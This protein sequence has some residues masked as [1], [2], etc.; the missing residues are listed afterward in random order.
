MKLKEHIETTFT[1][2][3]KKRYQTYLDL[4]KEL[5]KKK[6]MLLSL[7]LLYES[8]RLYLKTKLKEA[9]P[10]IVAKV[11]AKFTDAKG[12]EDLYKIGD[13]VKNLLWKNYDAENKKVNFLTKKEYEALQ[14]SV[15]QEIKKAVSFKGIP[16]MTQEKNILDHIAHTRNELSH[17]NA[18]GSFADIEKSIQT[19]L[20]DVSKRLI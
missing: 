8:S 19:L 10:D 5:F 2:N 6:Y 11:E 20:D 1:Y 18:K 13:F 14:K 7:S 15:P 17:A 4:A 9:Q 3:G 12:R 16:N